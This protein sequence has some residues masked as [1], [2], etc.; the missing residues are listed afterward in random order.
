M[1]N[2][3]KILRCN[4]KIAQQAFREAYHV[5]ATHPTIL[6][7]IGDA[8]T[9]YDV[10]GNYSRAMS[11]NFTGSPHLN[12]DWGP[13]TDGR[14]YTRQRHAITGYIYELGEDGLVHVTDR[15]GQVSKFNDDASWVEGPLTHVPR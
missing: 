10:F 5:I 11:P 13:F 12:N 14:L 15:E 8:N 9:Q 2:V 1:A 6:E 7:S 4:W 3:A